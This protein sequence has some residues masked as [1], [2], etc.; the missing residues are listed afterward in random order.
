MFANTWGLHRD[1]IGIQSDSFI[2]ADG[3]SAFR[4]SPVKFLKLLMTKG[5]AETA[6]VLIKPTWAGLRRRAVREM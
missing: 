4:Q 1:S 6:E 3:N 2:V 5:Q